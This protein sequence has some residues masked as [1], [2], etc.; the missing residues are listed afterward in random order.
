MAS[1]LSKI[2]LAGREHET[3]FSDNI[4]RNIFKQTHFHLFTYGKNKIPTAK[5]T[6]NENEKGKIRKEKIE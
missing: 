6:W 2:Y 4:I 5:N 1:F 3:N